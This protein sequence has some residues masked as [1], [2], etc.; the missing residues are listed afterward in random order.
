MARELH[1][2]SIHW[3]AAIKDHA[4]LT[5]PSEFKSQLPYEGGAFYTNPTIEL[6]RP[7]YRGTWAPILQASCLWLTRGGGLENVTNEKTELEA[8]NDS[9]NIGLGPANATAQADPGDINRSR[10]LQLVSYKRYLECSLVQWRLSIY[11]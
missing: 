7:H 6:A 1:S 4:L 8:V 9:A 10:Y 5:L 2:L 11:P 3:L